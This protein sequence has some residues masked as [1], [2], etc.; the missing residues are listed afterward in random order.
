[1]RGD[2]KDQRL[3]REY[4]AS[5]MQAVERDRFI[6]AVGLIAPNFVSSMFSDIRHWL[7]RRMKYGKGA[8]HCLVIIHKTQEL[9]AVK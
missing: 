5:I 3:N 9:Q 4:Q 8:A 6:Q 1:M 7:M 2:W